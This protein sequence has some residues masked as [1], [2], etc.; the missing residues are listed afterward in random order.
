MLNQNNSYCNVLSDTNLLDVR[1][2]S[3]YATYTPGMGAFYGDTLFLNLSS[4][5]GAW[6][7]SQW[8]KVTS[9]GCI[10]SD[11]VKYPDTVSIIGTHNYV[12]VA[13]NNAVADLIPWADTSSKIVTNHALVEAINPLISFNDTMGSTVGANPVILTK[14]SGWSLKGNYGTGNY[15]GTND[16]NALEVQV[17]GNKSGWID[18]TSPYLTS[19][20]FQSGL[21]NAGLYN[22]FIGFGSGYSNVSGQANTSVGEASLLWNIKGSNNTAIGTGSMVGK[23]NKTYGGYN[24]AVGSGSFVNVTKADSCVAVGTNSLDFDSIGPRCTA[25]GTY[26]LMGNNAIN[27]TAIG[28]AASDRNSSGYD[29]FAGGA[30]S[31]Y[32]NTTGHHTVGVGDS[33]LYNQTTGSR[34]TFIGN[35]AGLN[36]TTAVNSMGYGDTLKSFGSNTAR[37]GN[38]QI[39]DHYFWGNIHLGGNAIFYVK[40]AYSGLIDNIF[41][42]TGLGYNIFN[43]GNTTGGDNTVLGYEAGESLTS[44]S[45]CTLLGYQ[46][47]AANTT[48]V[49]VTSIGALSGGR[50]SNNTDVGYFAM[51]LHGG[52]DNTSVGMNTLSAS[53]NSSENTAIGYSAIANN[54]AGVNNTASGFESLMGNTIGNANTASGCYSLINLTSGNFIYAGGD[55]ALVGVTSANDVVGL[56]HD[57]GGSNNISN[58]MWIDPKINTIQGGSAVWVTQAGQLRDTTFTT[59]HIIFTPSTG[60]TV[61]IVNKQINIINPSGSIATLTITFPSS[62]NNNDII[63]IKYAQSIA[64][65][66]YSANVADGMAAPIQGTSITFTYDSSTSTWY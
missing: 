48:S 30:Y 5:H 12:N 1:L 50:G 54:T 44:A 49:E 64:A 22:T 34:N 25:I 8:Y 11:Y 59:T 31:L 29:N 28:Y 32:F 17:D 21:V 36:L 37:W 7:R 4:A 33:V 42:N 55:S 51:G 6:N 43:S 60:G 13:I 18:Y 57:A 66:T 16:A 52:N 14:S 3:P 62:A 27:N 41:G 65:V 47:C 38:T 58:T 63:I 40:N 23:Q 15:L 9:G 56:G 35:A 10:C 39:T 20:G 46:A 53:S 26:V 19:W 61:S 2:F 45:N 24:T